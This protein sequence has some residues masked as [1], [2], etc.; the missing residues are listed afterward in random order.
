[1]SEEVLLRHY[2]R[3]YGQ[4]GG[5]SKQ[6]ILLSAVRW[7]ITGRV[8]YRFHVDI[9]HTSFS[10]STIPTHLMDIPLTLLSH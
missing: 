2:V 9:R 6:N 1:M 10:G 4:F 5:Q 8:P 7:I 3:I